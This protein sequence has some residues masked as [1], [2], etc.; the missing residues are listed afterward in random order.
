[1]TSVSPLPSTPP[2]RDVA[3]AGQPVGRAA[4][5]GTA[6]P[7]G[8]PPIPILANPAMRL[9]SRLNVVV[10]E[11]YD[12][13]GDVRAKIPSDRELRAYRQGHEAGT[14]GSAALLADTF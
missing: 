14:A 9:D 1:M 12:A 2:P 13:A 4:S 10:L 11:F 6:A 3:A 8:L 7:S 5:E